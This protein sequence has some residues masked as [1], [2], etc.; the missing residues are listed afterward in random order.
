MESEMSV[1]GHRAT[2]D[3]SLVQLGD[4][5][6]LEIAP[7]RTADDPLEDQA[8]GQG[9][10]FY[11]VNTNSKEPADDAA[12]LKEKKVAAFFAPWKL[13]IEVHIVP[14]AEAPSGIGEPGV[15]PV[16]PAIGNAIFAATGK[17]LRSLPLISGAIG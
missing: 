8:E 12:M 11:V 6:L 1:V 13:K 10:G 4:Q 5:M 17:R 7:F 16:A 15:P 3:L 9:D 14:S 2:M